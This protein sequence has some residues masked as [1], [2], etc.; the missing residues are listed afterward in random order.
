ME[1]S[2]EERHGETDEG[3]EI[4]KKKLRK[5]WWKRREKRKKKKGLLGEQTRGW[6][7]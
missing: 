7:S 5:K 1:K 3:S 6:D 4:L 2:N